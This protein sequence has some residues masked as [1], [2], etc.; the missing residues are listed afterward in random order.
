MGGR[1]VAW[2][3][4]GPLKSDLTLGSLVPARLLLGRGALPLPVHVSAP[5]ADRA[6]LPGSAPVAARPTGG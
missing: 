6:Q 1:R 3:E 5:V 4:V 2:I